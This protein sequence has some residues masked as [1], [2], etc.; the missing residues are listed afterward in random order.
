M[1]KRLQHHKKKLMDLEQ[2][3][4]T[5]WNINEEQQLTRRQTP[6]DDNS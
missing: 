1:Q 6:N 4:K 2:A 3:Q 5:F